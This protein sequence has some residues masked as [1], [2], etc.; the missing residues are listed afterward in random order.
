M[1]GELLSKIIVAEVVVV[2]VTESKGLR[3]VRVTE[4]Q[5]FVM[6]E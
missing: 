4:S 2:L 1:K 6:L 3:D 5:A